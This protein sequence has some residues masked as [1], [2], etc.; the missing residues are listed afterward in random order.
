LRC[1][2]LNRTHYIG[3]F[4]RDKISRDLHKTRLNKRSYRI[5]GSLRLYSY[6]LAIA[7]MLFRLFLF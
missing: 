5:N 7:I 1:Q 4:I 3:P 6:L 2:N